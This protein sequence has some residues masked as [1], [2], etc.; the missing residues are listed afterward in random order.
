MADN[1]FITV[2]VNGAGEILAALAWLETRHERMKNML[3]GMGS[4]G[5]YV[6]RLYTHVS[7][8][9]T[10]RH[11]GHSGVRW[12]PGGA[13]GGGSWEVVSGVKSGSSRHPLYHAQGTGI[14]AGKGLIRPQTGK[15]LTF[16]KKG[17]PRRFRPWVRGQ[18]P[19]N[20]LYIA[21]GHMK[22]YAMGS[23]HTLGRELVLK[24][25]R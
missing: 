3:L 7:S 12:R 13:G 4:Y 14:Y 23:I 25:N 17:E 24:S 11:I 5:N 15:W 8:G 22:L 6:M 18:E 10:L 1:E 9:Y 20:F 21:Y 19:N 2:E 16:Q